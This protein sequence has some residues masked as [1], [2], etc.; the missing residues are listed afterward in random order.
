M[1]Q[2]LKVLQGL[3]GEVWATTALKECLK[4]LFISNLDEWKG[5]FMF[6]FSIIFHP[7]FAKKSAFSFPYTPQW[8]VTYWKD[9]LRWI[10]PRRDLRCWTQG[11]FI[12]WL[13]DRAWK[14]E[15]ESESITALLKELCR[16]ENCWIAINIDSRFLLQN[17]LRNFWM[18]DR[19]KISHTKKKLSSS[20]SKTYKGDICVDM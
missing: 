12:S 17:G 19:K 14:T 2:I 1:E 8:G 3:A 7:L 10:F 13:D 16:M 6:I 5:K 18:A 4:I 15:E 9:T 20:L 11:L